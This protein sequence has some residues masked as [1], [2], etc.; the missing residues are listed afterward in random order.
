MDW[1]MKIYFKRFLHNVFFFK[2]NVLKQTLFLNTS[3]KYQS[4]E[5][6]KKTV[7]CFLEHV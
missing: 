4:Y 6:L 5:V 7:F 3:V 2:A 1:D